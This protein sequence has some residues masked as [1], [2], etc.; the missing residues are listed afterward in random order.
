VGDAL[1]SF[2]EDRRVTPDEIDEAVGA[3]A[4]PWV[5]LGRANLKDLGP[6][7]VWVV[8]PG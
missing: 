5:S 3:A 6:T 4:E 2:L 7:R 1:R 8:R